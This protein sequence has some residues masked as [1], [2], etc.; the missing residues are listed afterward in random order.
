[1]LL[2]SPAGLRESAGSF[3]ISVYLHHTILCA[4]AT[5]IK[6]LVRCGRWSQL[7]QLT[8]SAPPATWEFYR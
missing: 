6:L 1:M 2:G 7:I 3:I 8:A 5:T 4:E